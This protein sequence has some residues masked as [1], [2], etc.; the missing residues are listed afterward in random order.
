MYGQNLHYYR[1]ATPDC[2]FQMRVKA[3]VVTGEYDVQ[4]LHKEIRWLL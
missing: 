3:D 1:C 2:P 4:V